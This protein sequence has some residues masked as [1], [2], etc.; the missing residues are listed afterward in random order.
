MQKRYKYLIKNTGILA[1]SNFSSKILVFLL[2]PLYTRVLTTTE[3]GTYD[4]VST[5]IQLILPI[6]SV[7]IFEAL[8]R[9][10]MDETVD[11]RQAITIGAKLCFFSCI[12]FTILIMV[13]KIIGLITILNDYSIITIVFFF[14]SAFY[15]YTTSV[16]KGMEYVNY[17]AIAG[18]IS[19][20]VMIIGNIIFLLW[21]QIGI[22]GF[23]ISSIISQIIPAIFIFWRLNIGSYIQIKIEKKVQTSM[24][25]Y[26]TPL[27]LNTVGWWMN[28]ALDRY[29]VTFIC[30]TA[31]NGIFSVA[32]KI[33][34]IL[35]TVQQIFIQAWQISAIKEY[36]NDSKEFY[37]K[38]MNFI[39][40]A[41]GSTCMVLIF[42]TKLLAKFLYGKDFYQAWK[43]V[44]F[45]L[46][47]G[48]LNSASGVLGPILSADKNSKSLG[49]STF[50]GALIN[51]VLNFTLVYLIGPQ[52]AAIATV[53]S[54]LAI[55]V[56]R[57]KSL[58][59]KI[60]Y[61]KKMQMYVSWVLL[62]IQAIVMI[63]MEKYLI[64]I[65]IIIIFILIYYKD[66]K[67]IFSVINEHF[68]KPIIKKTVSY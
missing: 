68:I 58:I 5:T 27:V 37:G 6:L 25:K 44:P 63:Y 34:T 9:Y 42:S 26:S 54:S 49:I 39:N 52:G 11:K 8:V 66:F 36:S 14:S 31:V 57:D 15:Q 32:Y 4:L 55:Y 1:I 64:Q 7:N 53:I 10:L 13:N 35:A 19:T 46:V 51:L 33:P 47:S 29:A 20:I 3:Y 23:F 40:I 60:D 43:Y 56:F 30:G 28:N 67:N 59:G 61:C 48:V 17:M 16:A 45:L 22:F 21:F 18:V 2:V 12:I 41:M 62:I 38:M 65:L 50:L 24:I